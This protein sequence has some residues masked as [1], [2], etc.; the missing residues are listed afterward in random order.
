MKELAVDAAQSRSANATSHQLHHAGAVFL[1]LPC[2]PDPEDQFF[3][4]YPSG[5]GRADLLF[6]SL[7][8]WPTW[9]SAV[10][11]PPP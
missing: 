7:L 2:D 9:P 8:V 10:R 1:A 5:P 3:R 6:R 11:S 4:Q